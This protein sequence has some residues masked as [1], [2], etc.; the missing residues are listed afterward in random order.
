MKKIFLALII[1]CLFWKTVESYNYNWKDYN[2]KVP[3]NIEYLEYLVM[4]NKCDM[5]K[6]WCKVAYL[7]ITLVKR[8]LSPLY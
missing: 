7:N 1:V 5:K 8:W 2:I 4:T 3:E 6:Y